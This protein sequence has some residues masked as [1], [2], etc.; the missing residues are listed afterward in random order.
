MLYLV[1]FAEGGHNNART[2]FH[3]QCMSKILTLESLLLQEE[4]ECK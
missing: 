1:P 3:A 4:R 2:R